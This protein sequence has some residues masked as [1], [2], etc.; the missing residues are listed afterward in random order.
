MIDVDVLHSV[1]AVG[2]QILLTHNGEHALVDVGD[3]TVRD[4]V[5]REVDFETIKGILMTHEHFDHF[6]GL[7]GFLHFCRLLRRKEQIILVVPKPARIVTHLL[8]S[9]VM[10]EPLPFDVRLIELGECESTSIGELEATAFSVE[11]GSANAFGYSIQD[12]QGFRVVVSGD[13]VSCKS[14]E[15][16]VE[17]A[18]VAVL[19]ATYAD[20]QEDLASKYGHMTRSQALALGKMAKRTVLVHSNPEY[21]FKKFQ[22]AVR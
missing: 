12:K 16:N 8:K 1:S 14:L 3:G 15:H 6:S 4:L 19:E 10:Y 11:H 2:T 20:D 17:G 7:Y 21:Y 5:S 9:P 22:C 13:T 18:D